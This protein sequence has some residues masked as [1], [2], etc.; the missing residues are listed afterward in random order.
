MIQITRDDN[1]PVVRF[2]RNPNRGEEKWYVRTIQVMSDY[3]ESQQLFQNGTYD[4]EKDYG[5]SLFR[6]RLTQI[7]HGKCAYCEKKI[8]KGAIEHYRPKGA[9]VTSEDN[10][11]Y[12][13]PG[14]YW[15]A[16]SWWNMV[17][18]CTD[19][20][21]QDFKGNKFP[22]LND[23][24][25][26][27]RS[28][29]EEIAHELPVLIDVVEEDPRIYIKYED[30]Y[31]I[32]VD[33]NERGMRTINI[34]GLNTRNALIEERRDKLSSIRNNWVIFNLPEGVISEEER[35]DA[36]NYLIQ[37]VDNSEKFTSMAYDFT[38]TLTN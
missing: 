14:Y 32:A 3:E 34:F 26:R 16:Y 28:H 36:L 27:C 24:G 21:S 35:Y 7:Q 25:E 31:A 5:A 11:V 10:G 15:L 12:L 8:D 9:V 22:I 37:C 38:S 18:A 4:L 30:E 29:L 20:N 19:C 1:P 33:D 13:Q 6:D 23:E 17:L 2:L